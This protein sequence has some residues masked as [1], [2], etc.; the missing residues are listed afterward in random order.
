M[1][2]ICLERTY[3]SQMLIFNNLNLSPIKGILDNDKKNK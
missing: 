1:K 2:F 3:F